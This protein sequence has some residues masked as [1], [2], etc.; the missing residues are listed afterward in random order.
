MESICT[1]NNVEAMLDAVRSNTEIIKNMLKTAN[2]NG[3]IINS[4][5]SD[6]ALNRSV[7]SEEHIEMY[8][9]YSLCRRSTEESIREYIVNM[10]SEKS[11]NML[12]TDINSIDADFSLLHSAFEALNKMQIKIME[13][14]CALIG[15]GNM[16]LACI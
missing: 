16:L 2:E 10:E 11:R 8:R 6:Y 1:E 14:L 9:D 12:T 13:M 3:R 15:K 4:R 7:L 5:L